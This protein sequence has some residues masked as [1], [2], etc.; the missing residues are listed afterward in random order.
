MLKILLLVM[1]TLEINYN[2]INYIHFSKC[3]LNF[4][5][6]AIIY[7]KLRVV[8]QCNIMKFDL[9]KVLHGLVDGVCGRAPAG[10]D[11]GPP[12]QGAQREAGP[13]QDLPLPQACLCSH[14]L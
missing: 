12:L 5:S 11:G 4:S 3:C 13:H 2:L 6:F 10:Q 8:N 1:A 9:V 7:H 14:S